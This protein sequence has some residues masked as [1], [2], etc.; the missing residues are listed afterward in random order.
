MKSRFGLLAILAIVLTLTV[1]IMLIGTHTSWAQDP[2]GTPTPQEDV[3]PCPYWGEGYGPMMGQGFHHG[4]GQG[5]MPR[6]PMG[7]SQGFNR[8]WG[9]STPPMWGEGMMPP[10]GPWLPDDALRPTEDSLLTLESATTVAEAFVASFEDENLVL[11]DVIALDSLF[12]AVVKTADMGETAF[13]FLI[14][15][16]TGAVHP[17]HGRM[18][19]FSQFPQ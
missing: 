9:Q 16:T 7:Q 10:F 11:G 5:M 4:R 12:Y 3:P 14:D 1:G 13:E 15:P 6:G 19:M 2:E 18:R 8:G 17:F